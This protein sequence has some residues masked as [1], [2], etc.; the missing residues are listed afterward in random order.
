MY[1]LNTIANFIIADL[2]AVPVATGVVTLMA[3]VAMGGVV[4]PVV[5][6]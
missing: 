6:A 4:V 5:I 1:F 3:A 2:A